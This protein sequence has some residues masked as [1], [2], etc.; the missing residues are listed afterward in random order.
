M[1]LILSSILLLFLAP[2]NKSK[3]LSNSAEK[4]DSNSTVNIVYQ[5]TPCFGRCPT[6]TMTING[7]SK[8]MSFVGTANTD[9]IGTF[10][11]AISDA[12]L[13][14]LVAEFEKAKFFSLDNE[15][16]GHIVDFPSKY[17]TYSHNGLNKKIQDR[18]GGPEAIHILEKVLEEIA[19]SEGWIIVNGE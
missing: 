8:Q 1:K 3:Q 10:T 19:N 15:Y 6:Y 2:C 18:S 14:N 13:T 4:P 17:I 7:T 9:K 11:K 12:E 16:L 5:T